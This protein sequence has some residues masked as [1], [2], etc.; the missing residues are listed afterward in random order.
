[1]YVCILQPT[2][3][4]DKVG[5]TKK[6]KTELSKLL[7]AVTKHLHV[8]YTETQFGQNETKKKQILSQTLRPCKACPHFSPLFISCDR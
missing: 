3:K 6:T 4:S 1:M 8:P 7:H 5:H 2:P